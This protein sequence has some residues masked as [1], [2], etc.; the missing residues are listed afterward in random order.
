MI[1]QTLAGVTI[2]SCNVAQKEL[3]SISN[4]GQSVYID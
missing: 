1:L 2:S 3:P 4:I